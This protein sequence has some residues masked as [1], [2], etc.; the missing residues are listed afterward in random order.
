M[1]QEA[2][3][4]IPRYTACGHGKIDSAFK[5]TA[6]KRQ[7]DPF[8]SFVAAKSL[9]DKR[10]HVG[11]NGFANLHSSRGDKFT[12]CIR[13]ALGDAICQ[14]NE[15]GSEFAI[16]RAFVIPNNST[17]IAAYCLYRCRCRQDSKRA[18]NSGCIRSFPLCDDP[19]C[20]GLR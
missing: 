14:I 1:A 2:I 18:A 3:P 10:R 9:E 13:T 7:F 19:V 11:L 5:I 15:T 6:N 17:I 20:S 8:G 12:D 16:I 4:R